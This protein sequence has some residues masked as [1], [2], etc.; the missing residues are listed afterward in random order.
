MRQKREKVWPL[1]LGKITNGIYVLTTFH[2]EEINGMII[3]WVSQ[4]SYEP[5]LVM[6]AI[7]PTRYS[8]N[9]V[10][11]SGCFALHVLARNQTELLERFMDSEPATKFDS[12]HWN[13]GESG[14]PILGNCV[15]YMECEVRESLSP[16]NHT[17]FIGEVKTA[18]VLSDDAPLNTRD[19]LGLYLGKDLGLYLGKD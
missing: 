9:L 14:C 7:H 19:Y 8:H 5:P 11:Q 2:K 13:K 12:I 1:I 4:V 15:A 18:Q 10:K 3:S 16:G 17:L 6:V